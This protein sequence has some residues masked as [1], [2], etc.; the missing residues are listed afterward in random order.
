MNYF[1]RI[2]A[3]SASNTKESV[4]ALTEQFL[5]WVEKQFL[6]GGQEVIMVT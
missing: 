6:I 1:K 3:I 4:C 5:K 2:K